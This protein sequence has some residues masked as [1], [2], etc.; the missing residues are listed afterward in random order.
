MPLLEPDGTLE[1]PGARIRSVGV[2]AQVDAVPADLAGGRGD[3][4]DLDEQIGELGVPADGA[5]ALADAL[6]ARDVRPV[7]AVPVEELATT[8]GAGADRGLDEGPTI[9]L[10]VDAPGHDEAQVL[11]EVDGTG[12]VSWHW[13]V[14]EG[15]AGDRAGLEQVFR[16][17]VRQIDVP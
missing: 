11:L 6:S 16:I 4:R 10:T 12:V 3:V 7:L 13:A 15:V 8:F 14:A 5:R 1:L 2:S 9:E 17:P